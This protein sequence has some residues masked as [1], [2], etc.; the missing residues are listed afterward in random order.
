MYDGY[1]FRFF[2]V[3]VTWGE[4]NT[5]CYEVL[6][7]HD[8]DAVQSPATLAAV[9]GTDMSAFIYQLYK[10]GLAVEDYLMTHNFLI[11]QGVSIVDTV[12]AEIL[13]G[14]TQVSNIAVWKS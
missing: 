6:V 4:A 3:R 12:C 10:N 2:N 8:D 9:K 13:I 1:C 11:V 5:A 14:T 7:D